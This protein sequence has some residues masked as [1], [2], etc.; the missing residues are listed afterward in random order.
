MR[1]MEPTELLG[2]LPT[3][4][5]GRHAASKFEALLPSSVEEAVLSDDEHRKVVS[6]G[7]HPRTLFYEEFLREKDTEHSP[8]AERE[9]LLA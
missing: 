5:F 4:A 8:R 7:A 3:W 9:R 6:G 2:M 1:E